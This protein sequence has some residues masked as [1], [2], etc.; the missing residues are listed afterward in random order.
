MKTV[1]IALNIA[2]IIQVNISPKTFSKTISEYNIKY[3]LTS[4]PQVSFG[5]PT[6]RF[7]RNAYINQNMK[8]FVEF[9]KTAV[10]ESDRIVNAVI[11]AMP[12]TENFD[13]YR[14]ELESYV[15]RLEDYKAHSGICIKKTV[16][17]MVSFLETTTLYEANEG[18]PEETKVLLK[19]Y[20]ENGLDEFQDQAE[21]WME[22]LGDDKMDIDYD[23][24]ISENDNNVM[25]SIFMEIC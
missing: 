17:L 5:G 16:E 13:P 8:D 9:A 24:I 1:F 19:L 25:A 10:K 15:R 20:K 2:L 3:P 21:K 4:I 23:D 6:T 14:K 22:I 12:A 18:M 11:E 7:K